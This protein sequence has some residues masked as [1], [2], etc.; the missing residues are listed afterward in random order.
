LQIGSRLLSYTLKRSSRHTIGFVISRT[1]LTITAPLRLSLSAIEAAIADKQRWIFSKLEDWLDREQTADP[2]PVDWKDGSVVPFY[3]KHLT[4]RLSVAT[5]ARYRIDH[6]SE[7]QTLTL[8]LPGPAGIDTASAKIGAC[9]RAWLQTEARHRFA[10]RLA[11]YAP[12]LGVRFAAFALSS[13][14]T[15]WGSCSSNGNI[16]LNWRLIHFSPDVVDYV[17]IHELAHLREMN[18]SPRFWAVVA[19]VMPDYRLARA[20]LKHPAPG[21]MPEL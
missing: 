13:A 10:D 8:A 15:R 9:L 21:M 7:A 18:H 19:A 11:L 20:L 17:V 1:G 5:G 12:I 14:R 4:L 6:D 2:V 16:R 3:G